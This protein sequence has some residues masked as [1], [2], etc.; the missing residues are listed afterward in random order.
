MHAVAVPLHRLLFI[1]QC[2]CLIRFLCLILFLCPTLFLCLCLLQQLRVLSK[3][4]Q[5]QH[6]HLQR[7]DLQC[8]SLQQRLFH[9]SCVTL[10]LQTLPQAGQWP[11]SN[12]AASTKKRAV[13]LSHIR[14]RQ[15]T[16]QWTAAAASKIGNLRGQSRRR[17]SAARTRAKLAAEFQSH[18]FSTV[19][20]PLVAF[21]G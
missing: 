13:R 16:R 12:G 7:P 17:S 8:L 6:L 15:S 19:C 9:F 4:L 14:Q 1:S 20:S 21:V 2:Q 5:Q 18:P 3:S 11:R 10:A